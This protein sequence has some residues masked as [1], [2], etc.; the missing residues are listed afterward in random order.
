MHVGHGRTYTIGDI[1]ARY[2]RMQGFHVLWP[3]AAHV[4]GTP[5]FG[6]ARRIQL[7]DP[8]IL[9]EY[10]RHIELYRPKKDVD[11]ILNTF[12]DPMAIA[13]FFA[14][15]IE[16]DFRKLGY[17]IDW[18]RRFTT[19]DPEYRAFVTWQFQKLQQQGY[20]T[21]GTYP[22]LYCPACKNAVGEDDLLEGEQA[23]IAEFV[24]I[25][26][27]FEDGYL[28]A[29]TLRPE[30]VYGVTNVWV[31][32]ESTYVKL[33]VGEEFWY[34]AEPVTNKL[35]LQGHTTE[36]VE[37]I[38]G[39]NFIGKKCKSPVDN[40]DL[41]ILPASFVD[42]NNAT[43]IVYSV[44]S[45]A[46]FDWVALHDLQESQPILRKYRL[47]VSAVRAIQ[48]ISIISIE[49]YGEHPAIELVAKMKIASQKE[50]EKLE[51]ATE[52]LYRAEYYSGIMKDNCGP[53][54]GRQ[55]SEAKDDVI[56]YLKDQ[57]RAFRFYQPDRQPVICRCGNVVGVAV[58]QNQWFINYG[59]PKWKEQATRVLEQM[60][61]FPE[62]Y[63][64]LFESTFEWLKERPC[65][66]RR[67]LGTPLPFDPKWVIE[68]LSDSTIY[69]AFYLII[70]H[71]HAH[72]IKPQQLNHAFFDY[73][74]L[75]KGD[76]DQIAKKTKI[77]KKALIAM[78]KE[79]EYWYPNDLRHTAISH[80]TNHLSFFIFHHIAI[81]PEQNWP[82]AITLNEHVIRE[83][84]KMSK[85][86]GNVIPLAEIPRRYGADLYR[87]YISQIGDLQ[88]IVDW[89]EKEVVTIQ[90]RLNRLIRIF[91]EAITYQEAP[92]KK[93]T[94]SMTSQ[95]ILSKI[96]STI[97]TATEALENFRFRSYILQAVFQLLGHVEFYLR[98][99]D[100]NH[101]ERGP[102]L[103]Y[104]VERW[105]KL[106]A[107]VMPHLCEEIWEQFGNISFV[108]LE[109]WPEPDTCFL[110]EKIED[111]M[112]VVIQT[113]TDIKE[114]KGLLRRR[115]TSTVHIYVS[116]SWKYNALTALKTSKAALTMKSLMPIIMQDPE[117]QRRGKA[118][119]EL[120][121]AL[122]KAGGY[123]TFVDKDTELKALTDN[124]NFIQSETKLTV[125]IQD[126][127]NPRDDPEGRAPKALP[128]RPALYLI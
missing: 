120:V 62:M 109:K 110:D 115:K 86:K 32:P 66:R 45:H 20:I 82:L 87:L 9:E 83:G 22:I 76:I 64:R 68:S 84:R 112:Q 114:I 96:N 37:E 95:W 1:I 98:R 100:K 69:M 94:L 75:G 101:P 92:L 56:A 52:T 63:R 122:I 49:G 106:L 113:I 124:L 41:L 31:N 24:S 72:N 103:R 51:E 40:R 53:F 127:D 125:S 89:R 34:V 11:R 13:K 77:T 81:F 46:P 78:R 97:K 55:I 17:S 3:M 105:V 44:P 102:V 42:P 79:V 108:S 117:I 67:G 123:W 28:V 121:Q 48:P 85:S 59:H 29:A 6:I 10:K 71:I 35:E 118:A 73:V 25:K 54:E 19:N 14:S 15:V 43:G 50:V 27:P 47:N 99:T 58:L 26:F 80:I 116:P 57:N 126:A 74:L 70:H 91:E 12:S 2:K 16:G 60:F 36:K 90:R 128:G 65:A 21:K 38:P 8:V 93:E 88:T 111:A 119:N 61:I 18:R 107:P 33:R 39:K 7:K 4:T 23:K 104:I 5:V 30:T